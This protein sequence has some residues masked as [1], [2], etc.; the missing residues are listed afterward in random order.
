MK[1]RFAAQSAQLE[2]A[3]SSAP[4]DQR[5]ATRKSSD[6]VRRVQANLLQL[7]ELRGKYGDAI[8]QAMLQREAELKQQR[9]ELASIQ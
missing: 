4:E 7:E 9:A 3:A 1:E 8:V 5:E 6:G 2:K